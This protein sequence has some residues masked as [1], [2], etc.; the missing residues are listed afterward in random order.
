[1]TSR[2][3]PA[4]PLL[5]AASGLA[6]CGSVGL[7]GLQLNGA[8]SLAEPVFDGGVLAVAVAGSRLAVLRTGR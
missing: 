4:V 2:Y 3:A 6:A 1:M 8:P 5:A 7:S